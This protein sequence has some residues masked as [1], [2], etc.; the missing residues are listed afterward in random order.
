MPLHKI[1]AKYINIFHN[2][3]RGN[4]NFCKALLLSN[5]R[6]VF[7]DSANVYFFFWMKYFG[8]VVFWNCKNYRVVFRFQNYFEN[9][10]LNVLGKWIV[11][12]KFW[13]S[14]FFTI[15][16]KKLF[17]VSSVFSFSVRFIFSLD[18]KLSESKCLTVFQHFFLSRA[19]FSSKFW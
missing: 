12:I 13:I 9:W 18:T 8:L 15:F 2:N 19:F 5:L 14:S 4:I 10:I 16:E 1:S 11:C 6:V 17:K 7:L 3:S